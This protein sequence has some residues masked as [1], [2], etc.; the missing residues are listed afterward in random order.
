MKASLCNE[1]GNDKQLG[2][3]DRDLSYI[4]LKIVSFQG[5]LCTDV[6]SLCKFY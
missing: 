4:L 1:S 2:V 6:I 5:V 3:L